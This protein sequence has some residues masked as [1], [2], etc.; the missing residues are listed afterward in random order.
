LI[1]RLLKNELGYS[2]V[3]VLAAILILSIAIIPMVGM[4]D[5]GLRAARTSGNY[6]TARALANQKLEQAKSAPYESVRTSFPNG[7]AAPDPENSER[8]S[9]TQTA[10]A[11]AGFS[12]MIRKQYL[13]RDLSEPSTNVGL[14]KVT[15]TVNWGSS[16]SYSTTGVVSR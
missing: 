6:D 4:F 3:E 2:L 10:D 11:P 5:A 14:M 8:T 16:N 1:R 15:V 9:T 13:A 12:Y 7:T